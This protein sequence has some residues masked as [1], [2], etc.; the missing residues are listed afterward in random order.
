LL[1]HTY[2]NNDS[3]TPTQI[4][5]LVSL[6]GQSNTLSQTRVLTRTKAFLESD[7]FTSN[8]LKEDEQEEQ[9]VGGVC[10]CARVCVSMCVS[11]S[12]CA[13]GVWVCVSV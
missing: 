7:E 8:V 2:S 6:E 3:L 13:C 5:H 4:A 11:V 12:V 1:V 9:E 10:V